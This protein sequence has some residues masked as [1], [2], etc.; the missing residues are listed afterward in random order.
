MSRA[1]PHT[2][3]TWYD[4][5]SITEIVSTTTSKPNYLIAFSSDKGEEEIIQADAS[6]FHKY[7]G[8]NISFAKHGQPLLT[9]ASICDAGGI[10]YCKRLVADDATLANVAVFA[11]I[12]K[13]AKE[14]KTDSRGNLLYTEKAS[15]KTVTEDQKD[16]M[17]AAANEAGTTVPTFDAIMIEP[18]VIK[19]ETK[20]YENCKTL[21]E[22]AA[23]VL[24]EGTEEKFPF[25]VVTDNGRGVSGKSFS[26][27]P[28][29][30][31]SK[32]RGYMRYLLNT[33][34]NSKIIESISVCI[35]HTVKENNVNRS[36][37][38]ACKQ[39]SYNLSAYVFYDKY[40]AMIAKIAEISGQTEDYCNS[41]DLLFGVTTKQNKLDGIKL[42]PDSINFSSM[43]GISLDNGSNGAFGDKPFGTDAYN[44]QLLKFYAGEIDDNIYDLDNYKYD[45]LVD[46]NYPQAVKRAIETLVDFRQ[47]CIFIEDAGIEGLYTI[48]EILATQDN[49]S[50]SPFVM[51]Y[52]IYYDVVDPYSGKQIT[53]TATYSMSKLLIPH[54]AN[55]LRYKPMCGELNGFVINEAVPD[56][57]NF[58]PKSTPKAGNQKEILADARINHLGKYDGVLCFETVWTTQEAYS[59]LSFGNNVLAIQEVVKAIR[60]FCP[61]NRFSILY[62]ENLQAYKEDINDIV[63]KYKNNFTS[64]A[65]A[66]GNDTLYEENHIYKA[67]LEFQCHNFDIAEEFDI[68]VV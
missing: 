20:S 2:S 62:G 38:T 8:D 23:K 67:A 15:G 60:A 68:Y 22:V 1:Y 54:F 44:E 4:Q 17:I 16:A 13:G 50:N 30:N 34:E 18:A 59:Q 6:D 21:E 43:Y 37:Y 39:D 61:A 41:N 14:Q 7:Y 35:N 3:F 58:I 11:T 51:L 64:I 48:D 46:C 57:E 53:V 52:P 25:F 28:E 42:D 19:Y 12:T 36:L 33:I 55:N 56:T 32:Q 40:D 45:V 63:N 5:S 49:V 9:A 26:I 29:Y 27:T 65:M 66:Y 24:E 31:S 47:D 10:V